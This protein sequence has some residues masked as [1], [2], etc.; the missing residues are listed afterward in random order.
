MHTAFEK[1]SLGCENSRDV[2]SHM[3]ITRISAR[4]MIG[5]AR[6]IDTGSEKS[7]FDD[8]DDCVMVF[9]AIASRDQIA[10]CHVKGD[11]EAGVAGPD[12]RLVV[13][14]CGI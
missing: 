1:E 5:E 12:V 7:E 2:M 14:S 4:H 10:D 6:S 9:R 8:V 3:S 11:S 13:A